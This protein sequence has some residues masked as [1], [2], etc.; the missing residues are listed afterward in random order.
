ML[1]GSA[2]P[3]LEIVFSPQKPDEVTDAVRRVRRFVAFN[4]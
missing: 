4:V 1:E 2:E 3:T